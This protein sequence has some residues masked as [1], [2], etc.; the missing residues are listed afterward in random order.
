MGLLSRLQLLKA[1]TLLPE[2][3]LRKLPTA[4]GAPGRQH[5][6]HRGCQKEFLLELLLE[7]AVLGPEEY[8]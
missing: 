2:H 3:Y 4:V 8:L 5:L 7:L 1:C 6:Q